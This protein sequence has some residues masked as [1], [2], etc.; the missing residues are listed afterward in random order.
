MSPELLT[1]LGGALGVVLGG[2]LLKAVLDFIGSRGKAKA[3]V[4][5]SMI[6]TLQAENARMQKRLSELETELDKE[7]AARRQME[8]ELHAARRVLEQR[9]SALERDPPEEDHG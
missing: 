5:V 7:R 6:T 9:V 1:L 2:G 8:T 3:D 4:A